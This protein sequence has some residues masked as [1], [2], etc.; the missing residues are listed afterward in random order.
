VGAG[1][2][3]AQVV[4]ASPATPITSVNPATMAQSGALANSATTPAATGPHY[5]LGVNLAN[6]KNQTVNVLAVSIPAPVEQ[7]STSDVARMRPG[8][9]PPRTNPPLT[10]TVDQ[11]AGIL[12]EWFRATQMGQMVRGNLILSAIDA[13]GQTVRRC[14]YNNALLSRLSQRAP[15]A[16][17]NTLVFDASFA[18][19][20]VACS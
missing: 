14:S 1:V 19:E 7:V 13:S 9:A 8:V 2:A 3:G 18:Y 10:V 17:R 11:S 12:M 15:D 16:S 4:T 6:G 20:S 5:T